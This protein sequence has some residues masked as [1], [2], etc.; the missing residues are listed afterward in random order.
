MLAAFLGFAKGAS[1]RYSE[2]IDLQAKREASLL[3]RMTEGKVAYNQIARDDAAYVRTPEIQFLSGQR[4][5]NGEDMAVLSADLQRREHMNGTPSSFVN[6]NDPALVRA[7]ELFKYDEWKLNPND[8]EPEV[9]D[10]LLRYDAVVTST[11]A[12]LY[13]QGTVT[14]TVNGKV[15]SVQPIVGKIPGFEEMP[16]AKQNYIIEKAAQSIGKSTRVQSL[17]GLAPD[18]TVEV[19]GTDAIIRPRTV[20]TPNGVTKSLDDPEV[21]AQAEPLVKVAAQSTFLRDPKDHFEFVL[22]GVNTISN[23]TTL[24]QEQSIDAVVAINGHYNSGNISTAV[25]GKLSAGPAQVAA[26]RQDIDPVLNKI[27]FGNTV[28]LM[29]YA[30]PAQALYTGEATKT[31]DLTV[32]TRN[33]ILDFK[34]NVLGIKTSDDVTVQNNKLTTLQALQTNIADL[35]YAITTLKGQQQ[36]TV[37][38]GLTKFKAGLLNALDQLASPYKDRADVTNNIDG[39]TEFLKGLDSVEAIQEQANYDKIVSFLTNQLAYNIARSLES[40]TGNARLSNIDVENA[41]ESLGLTGIFATPGAALA[42]LD[43]LSA[44]TTREIEYQ[45]AITSDILPRMQNAFLLQQMYGADSML[46]VQGFNDTS[47][48]GQRQTLQNFRNSVITELQQQPEFADS[49]FGVIRPTQFE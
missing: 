44:R 10:S 22:Q 31:L 19:Q 21:Q 12:E 48:A 37:G 24:T 35:Q 42:V 33:R 40:S 30:T 18:V 39:L 8:Y 20:T 25:T 3:K 16:V 38:A 9:R 14:D 34:A 43:L 13:E 49:Q 28:S 7:S 6:K 4:Q 26:I 47:L 45:K 5:A 32:S 41:K 27:G 46:R 23:K 11:L 36:G 2:N 15:V 1:E 17:L 29:Q